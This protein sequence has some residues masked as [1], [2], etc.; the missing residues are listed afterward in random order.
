MTP[1]TLTDPVSFRRAVLAAATD[2]AYPDRWAAWFRHYREHH[3][4]ACDHLV[5]QLA[6]LV[7]QD[8]LLA[9][10]AE[11]AVL[12]PWVP[13]PNTDPLVV[14]ID[15]T[16]DQFPAG[17]LTFSTRGAGPYRT[18][19]RMDACHVQ[20]AYRLDL[21]TGRKLRH[22]EQW[23]GAVH[24]REAGCVPW[25]PTV[26]DDFLTD[27][28]NWWELT[29]LITFDPRELG[30][31][32][33]TITM[34][35]DRHAGALAQL[36][37]LRGQ[38]S[39]TR[40]IRER[41]RGQRDQ[42]AT[43][44]ERLEPI[45]TQIITA[46]LAHLDHLKTAITAVTDPKGKNPMPGLTTPAPVVTLAQQIHDAITQ[47]SGGR[48]Q[49]GA[50]E[51]AFAWAGVPR[52]L[53]GHVTTAPTD[54]RH[55]T[56]VTAQESATPAAGVPEGGQKPTVVEFADGEEDLVKYAGTAVITTEQ[57]HFV[58]NIETAT[59]TVLIG[60]ILRAI[61]ADATTEIL[62][63][64]GITVA[65]AATLSAGILQAIADIAVNGG[66]ASFVGLAPADWVALVGGIT[67]VAI[68][69][70]GNL[71]GLPPVLVP[72]LTTGT[73]IVADGA[74]ITVWEVEGAPLCTV[75]PYSMAGTNKIQ[76]V[77]DTWAAPDV[78][79]PGVVAKV[80]VA[81]TP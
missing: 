6:D 25:W 77:L 63:Q 53:I 27:T 30:Y 41:I 61:E 42:L 40:R 36:A 21:V 23:P 31:W 57:A 39:A 69:N 51:Q 73:A 22:E 3:A 65:G 16:T 29:D 52:T 74:G 32:A 46:W 17:T 67:D 5:D 10:V 4:G 78:T 13:S 80:E 11:L 33:I 72:A 38:R 20:P 19:P 35:R 8:N 28:G 9:L 76:I 68:A 64:A 18:P 7:D 15:S 70:V 59:S 75:D 81:V 79:S 48:L 54:G 66:Q 37:D 26:P 62:A 2:P 47:G 45:G 24:D 49:V 43:W 55:I 1:P 71:F 14:P 50:Q 58:R 34:V 60:S 44:I 56:T 12:D